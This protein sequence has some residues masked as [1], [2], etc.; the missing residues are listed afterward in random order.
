MKGRDF[1]PSSTG[2]IR[3]TLCVGGPAT[4]HECYHCNITFPRNVD[5]FS[6]NML[7]NNKDEAVSSLLSSTNCFL[8]TTLL[9]SSAGPAPSASKTTHLAATRVKRTTM[10]TT[11]ADMTVTVLTLSG[12]RM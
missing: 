1:Q 9:H 7:K 5:Y 12:A 3:C 11:T 6:K 8:L 10:T 4:E 2:F